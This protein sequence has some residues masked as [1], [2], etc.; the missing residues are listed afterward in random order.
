MGHIFR[1][2][3]RQTKEKLDQSFLI[4][5]VFKE[6]GA[7]PAILEPMKSHNSSVL[8]CYE[9]STKSQIQLLFNHTEIMPPIQSHKIP[10]SI[11]FSWRTPTIYMSQSL[12]IFPV[13]TWKLT[14]HPISR[15]L[16]CSRESSNFL[17]L[18]CNTCNFCV[19]LN[20][21]LEIWW[22]MNSNLFKTLFYN[23]LH[24]KLQA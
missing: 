1:E 20:N 22:K 3:S 8:R 16:M 2:S 10:P 11:I 15:T 23:I 5:E 6:E 18:F 24:T 7:V 21:L 13:P 17:V 9:Y 19:S 14:H 4:F 12:K